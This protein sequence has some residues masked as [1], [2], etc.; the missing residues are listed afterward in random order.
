MYDCVNRGAHILGTRSPGEFHVVASNVY[1][2]SIWNMLHVTPLAPGILRWFVASWKIC[3]LL[4][5]NI[6]M[7]KKGAEWVLELSIDLVMSI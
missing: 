1:V 5:M 4:Y 7:K 3:A 2:S 6:I